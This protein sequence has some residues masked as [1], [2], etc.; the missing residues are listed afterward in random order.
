MSEP[1]D[2]LL[3]RWAE[4]VV[5]G[6]AVDGD[7]TPLT[8]KSAARLERLR[9]LAAIA[10]TCGMPTE[11][12]RPTAN[13]LFSWGPL[14]IRE[15][16]GAGVFG[17]V[18]L[19]WDTRLEREVAL[20]FLHVE[21][22]P[23]AARAFREGRNLA[24][25][26]HPNIVTVHGVEQLDGRVGIWMEH[27]RGRTLE[28]LLRERGLFT[29]H[30]AILIGIELCRA[31]AAVHRSGLVH[32]DV[33]AHNVMR[34][35]TGRIVLMDFGAGIDPRLEEREASGLAGTPIYLAP[36]ILRGEPA[37]ARSDLYGVGV[38]LYRLVT[39]RYPIEGSSLDSLHAAHA[40]GET[41][42]L[43]QSRP[44]LPAPFVRIVERALAAEPDRRFASAEQM[45]AALAAAL[46]APRR[47]ARRRNA[48]V[49]I[50]AAVLVAIALAVGARRL[51]VATS[52]PPPEHPPVV[53]ADVVNALDDPELDAVSS[54]LATSLD[55]SRTLPVLTRSRM[56]D[57]LAATG[58]ARG[59]RVDQ[60]SG[61]A[62]GRKAGGVALLVPSV[63]R[64]RGHYRIGLEALDPRSGRRR[65]TASEDAITKEL[66][67]TA[68]DALA[69]RVRSELDRS[70]E[71]ARNAVRPV[72]QITTTSLSAYHLYD[73]AER[74]ID[75]LEMPAARAALESAIARDSTFGL[76]HC[77]LAYVCW[78]LNDEK[79]ERAQLAKAFAQIDRVP[80][81]HRYHLRAQ[82]AMADRSGL[83]AARS[84]LLE[85]ERFYPDDKEMLYDIGDY[86]SHLNEFPTAIQYLDRVVAMDPGFARALQHEARIYRDLG[87]HDR[88]LEWARR[89][90]AAD[91]TWD[92]YVL[93]G[94]ALISAGH[95]EDGIQVMERGLT[96]EPGHAYDF[97]LFIA[98]ARFHLGRGPDGL[99][100]WDRLL[101]RARTPSERGA[102]LRGRAAGRIHQGAYRDA[103]ADLAS[104]A[105]LDDQGRN[106]VEEAMARIDAATLHIVGRNDRQAAFDQIAQCADLEG[107]ITYR[108]TYFNYWVYWGGLFKLR[109][110][111]GD[112]AGAE[113][114][115]KEKFATD[116]WYGPYV[117]AYLHAARG[118]CEQASAAASRVL[119]WG[120]AAENLPL[121]YFLGRCQFENGHLEEALESLSGMETFY[122][123]LEIGTPYYAKGLLLLGSVH[124]RRGESR[125]AIA[126]YRKLLDMWQD[127][128]R[129]LADYVDARRRIEALESKAAS[130]E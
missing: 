53:V 85:M 71:A 33:K 117:A 130:R 77:R 27:V 32:R 17:E 52:E 95:P 128:D 66:I 119:E 37:S 10:R 114:L 8:E 126:S 30:E 98:N 100:E 89:Y 39:G 73:Q 120:P 105:T 106:R 80:E 102:Y 92:S 82:G 20:K 50:A 121:R 123:H 41:R 36:E 12:P 34:E 45:E 1:E 124:E 6:R 125:L 62:I 70:P 21:A 5:D 111:A 29:S 91:S 46:D 16:L 79:A 42:S 15:R 25:V 55:Q 2:D 78:W 47:T 96:K 72:A 24:R 83:E 35:D 109:L 9:I 57:L 26:R 107:A 19:A 65:F 18:F 4:S 93:L 64:N 67:P 84:I 58:R 22:T 56:N 3:L 94:N 101:G 48:L 44:G 76:A 127:G 115:A 69:R 40:R 60:A 7:T 63:G 104:A 116:K 43:S 38:L 74:L 87:R 49:G 61:V 112:H 103:L 108:D 129:D 59:G 13:V 88:F 110:F 28:D 118:E 81:R 11:S 54:M 90:A 14:E 113:A 23:A 75:R 122:S 31:L 68:V 51:L 97:H 99:R 86:S